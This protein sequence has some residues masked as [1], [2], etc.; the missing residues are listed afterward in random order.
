MQLNKWIREYAK[1]KESEVQ[2]QNEMLSR[3][4]LLRVRVHACSC[5]YVYFYC[6]QDEH[7][8]VLEDLRREHASLLAK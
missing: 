1:E 5:P 4:G 8:V 7:N 3:L 6:P 2:F